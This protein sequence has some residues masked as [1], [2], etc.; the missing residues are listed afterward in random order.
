MLVLGSVC[1]LTSIFFNLGGS[2]NDKFFSPKGAA[3]LEDS[4]DGA[5]TSPD[6]PALKEP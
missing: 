5:G 1:N 6:T 2:T 3:E 4:K